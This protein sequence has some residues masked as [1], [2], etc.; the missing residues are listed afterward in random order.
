[1]MVLGPLLSHRPTVKACKHG[2][3]HAEARSVPRMTLLCNAPCESYPLCT[4]YDQCMTRKPSLQQ[5]ETLQTTVYLRGERWW[6]ATLGQ[7]PLIF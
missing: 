4:L 5:K 3:L 1:M 2:L 7:L 6:P